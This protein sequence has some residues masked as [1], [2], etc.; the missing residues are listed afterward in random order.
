M[1]VVLI[2]KLCFRKL[3][4][5]GQAML[6]VQSIKLEM[7]LVLRTNLSMVIPRVPVA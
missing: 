5:Q 4:S 3:S 1:V 6:Q 7:L 2:M